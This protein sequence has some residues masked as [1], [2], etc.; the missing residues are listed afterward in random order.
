[1]EHPV[2]SMRGFKTRDAAER[3][4]ESMMNSATCC[5]PAPVTIGASV[6]RAAAAASSAMPELRSAFYKPHDQ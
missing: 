2:A 3:F 1:M 4:A 6:H 5:E